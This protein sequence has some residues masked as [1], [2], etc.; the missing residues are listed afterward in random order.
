MASVSRSGQV[1]LGQGEFNERCDDKR[2]KKSREKEK[3]TK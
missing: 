1:W 2:L 3:P